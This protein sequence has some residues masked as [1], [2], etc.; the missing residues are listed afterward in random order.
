MQTRMRTAIILLTITGV[1]G[2][3]L[4][5][6]PFLTSYQP[7]ADPWITATTHHV[8]TGTVLAVISLAAVLTIIG[9][10]LRS[11][12]GMVEVAVAMTDSNQPPSGDRHRQEEGDAWNRG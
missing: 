6:A 10:A 7:T 5:V 1:A 2:I 8:A 3:W 12:D 4:A 9:S 11:L